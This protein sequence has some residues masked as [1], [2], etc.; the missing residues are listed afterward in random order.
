MNSLDRRKLARFA[1]DALHKLPRARLYALNAESK[2]ALACLAAAI[3]ADRA[4]R[5]LTDDDAPTAQSQMVALLERLAKAGVNLQQVRPETEPK[6]LPK[7]W[8]D[9]VTGQSLP[10]PTDITGKTLLRK[11]DPALADHYDAMERDPYGHIQSLHEA[12]A[13]REALAKATYG[14]QE[15]EI[16]PFKTGDRKMQD[17]VV[18]SG[19][20]ELV[21]F[22]QREAA[23][24]EVPLFRRE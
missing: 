17:A 9:P 11:F 15:H 5:N 4:A 20:D 14:E 8:I 18:K 16:N 23:D 19:P 2:D 6:P 7:P 24:V 3:K 13:K 10:P 22:Y 1:V 12:A 21:A